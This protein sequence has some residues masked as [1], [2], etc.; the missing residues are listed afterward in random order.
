MV[1]QSRKV[2]VCLGDTLGDYGFGE[3]H[4]FSNQ[5]Y[6]AFT[7]EL[8]RRDLIFQVEH[9]DPILASEDLLQLF[10]TPEYIAR[11]AY[12]STTG[13]GTLD[14]FGDTPS[15][16]G[17][18][19]DGLRVVGSVIGATDQV[20]QGQLRRAFIPIAGLHHAM[21]DTT[22][23]FCVFNDIGVAIRH[24]QKEYGLTR[25][26]YVDIDAHHGDGLFYPFESDPT[27]IFA[28]IHEDG[29]YVFPRTGFAHEIGLGEAKGKKLNRSLLPLQGDAEFF[30]HWAE[31]EAFLDAQQPEIIFFQ[32][33]CDGLSGDPLAHLH[34]S[35]K[36]HEQ[37]TKS[38][39]AL[40]ERHAQGR[41]VAVGGGGYNLY[42]LARAWGTVVQG[43]LDAPMPSSR[44]E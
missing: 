15:Y 41:L 38:L 16:L 42:N 17:V 25:V 23:G 13:E 11:I 24:V 31:V 36:V 35:L 39:C 32:A 20:M 28:D 7:D 43:L 4:P 10:H 18:F 27:V 21:P 26:A 12:C 1:A 34:Y 29:E 44:R 3:D 5:R 8:A 30:V 37:V 22:A 33:G 6:H 19:E 2:G 9:I 14:A 40:A